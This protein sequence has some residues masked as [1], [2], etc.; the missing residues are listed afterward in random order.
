MKATTS[1]AA[2][3][4]H[5][6][7][8]TAKC[9]LPRAARP[10]PQVTTDTRALA[11][12]HVS[13]GVLLA[14]VL[15]HALVVQMD[16]FYPPIAAPTVLQTVPGVRTEMQSTISMYTVAPVSK[17]CL[18]LADS[19]LS[20]KLQLRLHSHLAAVHRAAARANLQK[21]TPEHWLEG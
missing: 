18:T 17:E 9:V 8:R 21:Q 13:R 10:A 1:P 20:L 12:G 3:A 7:R 16:I 2:S 19:V 4:T 11:V 6:N 14:Q 15:Q 5:A